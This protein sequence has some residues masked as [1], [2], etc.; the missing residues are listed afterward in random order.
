MTQKINLKLT[1][2]CLPK[3]IKLS[4]SNSVTVA[5]IPEHREET[6]NKIAD[7][8]AKQGTEKPSVGPEFMLGIPKNK[9]RTDV[10]ARNRGR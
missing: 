6:G 1:W 5:C 8:L 2:K 10:L 3:L 9:T 4:I 7:A